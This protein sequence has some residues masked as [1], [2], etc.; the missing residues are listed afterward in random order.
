MRRSTLLGWALAAMAGLTPSLRADDAKKDEDK[1]ADA[2]KPTIVVEITLKGSIPEEPAAVGLD[3]TPITDNLQGILDRMAK[4]RDDKEVKALILK[5]RGLTVGWARANELREAITAFRKSGKKVYAFLEE[6]D[7]KDYFV[8]SAADEVVIPEGGWVML[9]GMA[10]EVTFYKSLFDKLGVKAD[11]MQV[12]K[13]KSYG[14]PY[15]RTAMSPAFRE[16]VAILLGDTYTLLAESLATRK[17]IDVDAAK[18][19]IDGGPYTPREAEKAGIVSRVA[20]LDQLESAIKDDL[21]AKSVKIDPKYGKAKEEVDFSGLAGFLKMMQALSGESAKKPEST[22]PKVA[23]IYASGAIT[24]GKST[25]GSL[26]GETSMGSDTVIKHLKQAEADKS[27]KAIVLRVDSPGGSALASDLIWREVTR[28][29]KPIVASMG[30]V[31]ASGGY[32]ISMGADKVYAE[33][34]TITGSIGVT[35]GKFVL[36]GLMDKL[37]VATDTVSVGKNGTILSINTPFSESER[38]A[39]QRLMDE[40]YKQFVGKAATGRK[41]A[42]DDLDKL[43]GGRVYTG[44][45]A[46]ALHLVDDLG[47]L[48]DAVASAKALGGIP[49]DS[50]GEML[51][52]PKPQ[53]VFESLFGSLDDKDVSATLGVQALGGFV[54]EAARPILARLNT[55][56]KLLSKEP[57]ALVMPFSLE[58]R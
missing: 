14:E 27:V 17:K 16:E 21:G 8:A 58:I 29:E 25:G 33:P 51:I 52:L 50:K 34:G 55:L 10:A 13:Y 44:R 30:D 46:K 11:W 42:Y 43:A 32:Y 22:A 18:A 20:Y 37:G 31:A 5:V 3:G 7:N 24:S 15:T 41:M 12:G 45:Q 48:A 26:L 9:K 28:I 23:L 2:P 49:A 1:K 40:T 35:G 57:V 54:P 39:M 38:A 36:G 19:L 53:G 6:V 47:T 4:A 56:A